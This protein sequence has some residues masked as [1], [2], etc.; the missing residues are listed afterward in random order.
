MKKFW[1]G[2]GHVSLMPPL[3]LPLDVNFH[4]TYDSD[5]NTQKVTESIFDQFQ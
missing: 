4:I 2:G 5:Q 1:S 3:D